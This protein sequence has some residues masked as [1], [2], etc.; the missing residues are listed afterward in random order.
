VK[1]DR[2]ILREKRT[3]ANWRVGLAAA[4]QTCSRNGARLT[5]LRR[6][7]LE[8]VLVSGKPVGAYSLLKQLRAD[9]F[10]DAPPTVYR[11]LEF[12]QAQRLVH[13]I[14]KSNTF[15]ACSHPQDDHFG[16]IF[17]CRQCGAAIELEEQRITKGIGRCARRLGFRLPRQVFEVEGTCRECGINQ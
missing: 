16:L 10:N 1:P 5:P 14:A 7:V 13:R 4:E 6:R 17:L 11:T 9:G 8:L 2:D 15:L 3:A 12:L